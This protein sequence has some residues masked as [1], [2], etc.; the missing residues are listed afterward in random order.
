MLC[1]FC[2]TFFFPKDFTLGT[3]SIV[4]VTQCNEGDNVMR[5]W[6]QHVYFLKRWWWW[7]AG[8]TVPQ[9]SWSGRK[10]PSLPVLF[11]G[12]KTFYLQSVKGY[13][14]FSAFSLKM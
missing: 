4:I 6:T 9:S 10:D 11:K 2:Q 7:W 12:T 14:F 3:Q 1:E 5:S 13:S 8:V